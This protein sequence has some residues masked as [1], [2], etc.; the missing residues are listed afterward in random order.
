GADEL[1]VH[2]N[3]VVLEREGPK[4][5]VVEYSG[6]ANAGRFIVYQRDEALLQGDLTPVPEFTAWGA[7]HR[8]FTADFSALQAT[9]QFRVEIEMGGMEAISSD[10]GVADQGLFASA[11][12]ALVNYFRLSRHVKAADHH[13]RVF[14]TN[15]FVDVWGG[16][17]D[18]GGDN[19]KYLTH[20]S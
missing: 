12:D 1:R 17:K 2:L 19:G 6:K 10:F 4:S 15:Q 13:I 5:A 14:G 8:Y 18:A 3:Q 7:G 11:A 16:W 20:L 9:G